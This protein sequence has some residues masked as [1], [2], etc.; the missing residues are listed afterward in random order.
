LVVEKNYNFIKTIKMTK[1][2]IIGLAIGVP[3]LVGIYLY[4]KNKTTK[5]RKRVRKAPVQSGENRRQQIYDLQQGQILRDEIV[6]GGILKE[7]EIP[8]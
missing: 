1:K 7:S 8:N 2:L 6:G 5:Q 4:R 3:I